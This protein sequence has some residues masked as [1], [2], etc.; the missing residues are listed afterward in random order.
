MLTA[1]SILV[2]SSLAGILFC[3][4]RLLKIN[5]LKK[6][7]AVETIRNKKWR[8]FLIYAIIIFSFFFVLAVSLFFYLYH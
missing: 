4:L 5:K 3:L 7:N 1:L 6:I 8:K 2:S